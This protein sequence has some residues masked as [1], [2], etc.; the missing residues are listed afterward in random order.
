MKQMKNDNTPFFLV[1]CV[2]SGTTILRDILRLHPR[3][4][5]P[6]ETH[7]F[8]WGE[9]FG[10][11]WFKNHYQNNKLVKT[12]LAMDGISGWELGMILNL[13]KSKKELAERYGKLYLEKQENPHGRWFDKTPQN[14]YGLLELSATFPGARFVHIYRNPLNVVSSLMEGRVMPPHDIKAAVNRWVESMLILTEY[15]KAWPD[16]LFEIAYERFTTH[17]KKTIEDLLVFIG[18]DPDQI[19]FKERQVHREKNKYKKLLDLKQIE[20]VKQACE[21]FFSLYGYG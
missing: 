17:T 6:E 1:G 16:R 5:C 12:H 11:P 14:V 21:P 2:R 15:K 9:A 8:R 18:E 10:T 3:L 7:F 19:V 13:V 20:T 4:E